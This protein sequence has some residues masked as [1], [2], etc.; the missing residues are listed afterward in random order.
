MSP[1]VADPSVAEA[2][3]EAGARLIAEHE[4]L[5]TRRLAAEVGTSTAAVYTHFGN[6][7][8]LRRA[9]R[10]VGFERLAA[11]QTSYDRTDDPVADLA[12]QGWAYC[13]NALDNPN[14]Y[15]VM[16][17][18][19]PV[20]ESDAE[21]G[22]Y[23]FQMLVDEVRRCVEAGRF[24]GDPEDMASQCWASTHGVITLH[25]AGMF[26]EAEVNR[27]TAVIGRALFISF[28]DRA[29]ETDAALARSAEWIAKRQAS[30]AGATR[31]R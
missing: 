3:V 20:D 29:T 7:N 23:T 10:R 22:L 9:V 26:D 24:R 19:P 11:Y 8:E 30:G 6:I 21:V 25:L 5:S 12:K 28:G 18:E 4:Q 14:M 1:R 15:R 13:R 31:S 16:F 17:M 2:L 27:L